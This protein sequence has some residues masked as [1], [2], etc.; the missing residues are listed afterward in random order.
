M[1]ESKSDR[2]FK[3]ITITA[4]V[5][6]VIA[7]SI[8]YLSLSKKL[9]IFGSTKINETGWSW[10]IIVPN[11]K[12][13]LRPV[14]S[15]GGDGNITYETE[16]YDG[17]TVIKNLKVTLRKPGDFGELTVP[18]KNAGDT[19]A[20]LAYV[21]GVDGKISCTGTGNTKE[22]DERIICGDSSNNG[23]EVRYTITYDNDLLTKGTSGVDDLN[24]KSGVYKMVKIKVEYLPGSKN[25]STHKV[26]VLLP[27]VQFIFQ[28]AM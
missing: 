16:S 21:A 17:V 9:T 25:V 26:I 8:A 24:L 1:V 19:D 15:S 27:E 12:D 5:I 28:Q 7:L 4:L 10:N 23:A 3:I 13:G 18:I 22:R 6:I 20:Y 2:R 11:E 14:T